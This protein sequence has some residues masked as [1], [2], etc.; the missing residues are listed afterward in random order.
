VAKSPAFEMAHKYASDALRDYAGLIRGG[1]MEPDYKAAY[2]A[3][4]RLV[5]AQAPRIRAYA[6]GLE[7]GGNSKAAE[8]MREFSDMLLEELWVTKNNFEV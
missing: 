7:A 6:E 1:E 5:L 4:E 3:M 2:Q 8:W